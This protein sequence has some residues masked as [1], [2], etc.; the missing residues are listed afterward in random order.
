M[1][2]YILRSKARAMRMKGESVKN[3]A[4]TLSVSKSSVSTWVRDITLTVEQLQSL[5]NREL[6]G[7]ELGRARSAILKKE[8]RI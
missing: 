1:P 4:R 5:K 8:R 2:K 3:I 7:S 6:K